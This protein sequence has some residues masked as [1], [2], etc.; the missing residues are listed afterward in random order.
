MIDK[1]TSKLSISVEKWKAKRK[2]ALQTK[3]PLGAPAVRRSPQIHHKNHTFSFSSLSSF[4][5]FPIPTSHPILPILPTHLPLLTIPDLLSLP[6]LL[7]APSP[8]LSFLIA[9]SRGAAQSSQD[10]YEPFNRVSRLHS[11]VV[12]KVCAAGLDLTLGSQRFNL[13]SKSDIR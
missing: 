2:A 11:L 6:C 13:I 4:F 8:F 1:Y 10:G 9:S 7:L 12:I 5:L 3:L